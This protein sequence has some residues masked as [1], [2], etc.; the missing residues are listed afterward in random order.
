MLHL[1]FFYYFDNFYAAILPFGQFFTI[2]D[3]F[4][5]HL[6]EKRQKTESTTKSSRNT[7][8]AGETV[9]IASGKIMR[10]IK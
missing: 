9:E 5:K 10:K 1:D 3:H 6:G 2:L 8:L 7:P 4:D